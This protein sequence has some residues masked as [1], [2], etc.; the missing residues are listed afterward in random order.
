MVRIC[1]LTTVPGQCP[2][3]RSRAV[4]VETPSDL[5][6]NGIVQV[7]SLLFGCSMNTELD[8]PEMTPLTWIIL[9]RFLTLSIS[10]EQSMTS[11][12]G[13]KTT[14]FTGSSSENSTSSEYLPLHTISGASLTGSCS[15]PLARGTSD[16]SDSPMPVVYQYRYLNRYRSFLKL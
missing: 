1:L 11:G 9:S 15:V 8:M 7:L 13:V 2:K 12:S 6:V 4:S 10:T 3:V 5:T 14:S 16:C